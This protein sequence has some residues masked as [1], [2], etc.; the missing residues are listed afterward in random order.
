MKLPMISPPATTMPDV[1][2]HY[3]DVQGFKGIIEG[4]GIWLSDVSYCNDYM[5]HN[6]LKAKYD[7][8]I[9]FLRSHEPT[10]FHDALAAEKANYREHLAFVSC[11][12]T[13]G[14][15]LSQWRAYA[16]DGAGFAIGFDPRYFKLGS[17]LPTYGSDVS[18]TCGLLPV[19]Y[20]ELGQSRLIEQVLD[21][22][23]KSLAISPPPDVTAVAKACYLNLQMMS[24]FCKNPAFQEESEWRIVYRPSISR[25]GSGLKVVG[26]HSDILFRTSKHNMVP[27]FKLS[28]AE[29][30]DIKPVTEI[31]R[32]PKRCSTDERVMLSWFLEKNGSS[33]GILKQSTASYR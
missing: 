1:I 14:D 23:R 11:F 4:K 33:C 25:L 15:V 30:T 10:D 26:G 13:K 18:I 5:E 2:Y 17:T 20:D 21:E 9:D 16:D 3:C 32:G 8:K 24:I 28:F 29:I 6:W 27:Y 19:C 22:Y 12:S 31:I 7:S